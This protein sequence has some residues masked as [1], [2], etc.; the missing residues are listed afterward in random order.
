MGKEYIYTNKQSPRRGQ[1]VV[2]VRRLYWHRAVIRFEDGEE[3]VTAE[4]YL[5]RA[6]K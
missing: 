2:I 6:G 1:R 4:Q 5:E 3:R